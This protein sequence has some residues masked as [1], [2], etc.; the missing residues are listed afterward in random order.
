[1]DGLLV[2]L[3]VGRDLLHARFVVQAPQAQGAVVACQVWAE[4]AQIRPP[5]PRLASPKASE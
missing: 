3:A 2:L 4:L 5:S 1:M